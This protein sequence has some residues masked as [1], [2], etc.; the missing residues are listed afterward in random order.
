MRGIE[1]ATPSKSQTTRGFSVIEALLA[2]GLMALGLAA[3]VRLSM[4]SLS[5]SQ[6]NRN[7][8]IASALAQDLGECWDVQTPLCMQQFASTSEF[9]PFPNNSQLAWTR[10]W[11]VSNVAMPGAPAGRLKE[12]RIKITWPEGDKKSELLWVLRR[13][14]TPSWVDS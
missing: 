12:L 8:D 13:A 6:A 10:T 3:S 4:I 11:Q 14:S 7:F 5:A 1:Q 9:S 2:C